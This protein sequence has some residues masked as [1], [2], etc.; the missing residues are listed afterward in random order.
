VIILPVVL[1]A[2]W[3]VLQL[4]MFEHV[5]HV[6][7]AAAQDAAVAAASHSTDPQAV[8]ASL[9]SRSAGSLAGNVSV[10]VSRSADRVS[11]TVTADVVRIFPAGTYTVHAHASAP[12]EAFVPEPA[13]P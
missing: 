8:A 6:A 9:I 10:S 5:Q 4:V 2:V 7:E 12:I 1:L 13:R 11:V 3:L